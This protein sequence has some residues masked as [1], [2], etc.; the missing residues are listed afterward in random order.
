LAGGR[1]GLDVF[2]RTVCGRQW[3]GRVAQ[4]ER[5]HG[6]A[7]QALPPCCRSHEL[8]GL[9]VEVCRGDSS[10]AS[11]RQRQCAQPD[12][13]ADLQH[14]GAVEDVTLLSQPGRHSQ[15][16]APESRGN[17]ALCAL[18]VRDR[19]V[20]HECVAADVDHA[21]LARRRR[22]EAQP[23]AQPLRRMLPAQRLILRGGHARACLLRPAKRIRDGGDA[24]RAAD[25]EVV[26]MPGDHFGSVPAA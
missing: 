26:H 4:V 21:L 8:H 10:C 23:K 22:L 18:I 16:A 13:G 3:R 11:G 1:A 12:P 7:A 20:Q 14:R 19:F 2:G 17:A 24:A 25:E 6:E 5:A 9:L 15:R